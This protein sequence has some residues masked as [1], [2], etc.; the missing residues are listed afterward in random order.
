MYEKIITVNNI[1][2]YTITQTA[3]IIGIHSNTLRRWDKIS[4]TLEDLNYDRIIPKSK[5]LYNNKTRFWNDE[6]IIKIK[7]FKTSTIQGSKLS[8]IIEMITGADIDHLLD[9]NN[10]GL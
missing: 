7:K 6:D 10:G 2:Y 8:T 9:I 5:Q 3:K 4:D 1:R